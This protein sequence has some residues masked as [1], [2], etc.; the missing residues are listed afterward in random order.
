M[1]TIVPS[2]LATLK[3]FQSHGTSNAYVNCGCR[4]RPCT[5]AWTAYNAKRNAERR[6]A[7]PDSSHGFATT[8]I[9]YRCRCDRCRVAHTKYQKQKKFDRK[10]PHGTAERYL[11]IGCQCR[12]CREAYGKRRAAIVT[13]IV[14]QNGSPVAG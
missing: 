11:A 9:N 12:L 7:I 2:P 5:D 3:P 1:P 10:Y 14:P 8:Y 4:C 6:K 13:G